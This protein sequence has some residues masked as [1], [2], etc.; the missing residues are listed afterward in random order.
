MSELQNQEDIIIKR[1]V[2]ELQ[3]EEDNDLKGRVH[4]QCQL[5]HRVTKGSGW[6]V[7]LGVSGRMV[8]N[9]VCQL[10]FVIFS[11]TTVENC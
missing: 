1:L 11:R 7:E 5:Q 2:S 9:L 4:Y 6:R 3:D 10:T 8:N